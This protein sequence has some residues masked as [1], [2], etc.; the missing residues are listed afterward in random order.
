LFTF[1]FVIDNGADEGGDVEYQMEMMKLLSHMNIDNNVVGWYQSMY[2]GTVCTNDV[3]DFQY[4]F[5]TS[6]D[7][8]GNSVVLMYDPIQTKKGSLCI[9]AYRLSDKFLQLKQSKNNDYIKPAEIFEELPVRVK[10]SGHISAYLRCLEDSRQD[11]ID[12]NFYEPLSLVA[13]DSYAEKHMELLSSWIDDLVM[14]SGRLHSHAKM[15]GKPRMEYIRWLAKRRQENFER[16]ENGETLLSTRLEDS[17]VKPIPDPQNRL[18]PLLDVEQI[19]RYC[20]QLNAHVDSTLTK[21]M[22][23]SLLASK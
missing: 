7:L 12:E 4:S 1:I 18:D 3:I 15:T 21:V 16:S 11:D 17:G 10:N 22:V 5:Q 8:A 9:K 13:S 19:E 2:M 20:S 23:S 14:E 6:E